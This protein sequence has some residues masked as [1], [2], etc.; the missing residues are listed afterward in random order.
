MK[1]TRPE[2][3]KGKRQGR[4]K[5][6]KRQRTRARLLAAAAD[7][8]GERGWDRTSLDEVARRAGMTRGAIYGN[9]KNREELFLATVQTRWKPVIP[10][11]ADGMTFRD[12]MHALGK[13]VAAAT[14]ARRAQAVGALSFMLYALTHDEMRVQIARFNGELY[15]RG[16]RRFTEAFDR[17]ELPI[18]PEHL[19]P[20]LH[21][22]TDG[23]TFLRFM[24]PELITDKMVVAAFDALAKQG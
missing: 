20:V 8:I 2:P 21:A 17:S 1:D 9:F 18:P 4:P 19:I 23:L 24:T 7:V 10:P 14:P 16:A 3:S 13:A 6:D 22:L 11:L 5:G 12:Y 15:G